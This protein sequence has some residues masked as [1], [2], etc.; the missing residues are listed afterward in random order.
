MPRFSSRIPDRFEPNEMARLLEERGAAGAQILDL[1]ESNPT[2][3][4]L[5][6]AP[7]DDWAGLMRGA[8][9]PYEP[10]PLG[11]WVT[12][13]AIS[14]YY[15]ESE[16]PV[17]AEHIVLTA[18]TSEAYAHLFRIFAEPGD[19]FLIPAPSYPLFEP[20][21]AL[22]SVRLVRYPLE[23][24]KNR[25]RADLS[26]LDNAIGE[27]TR[28]IIVVHPNNP[29][30]SLLSHAEAHGINALCAARDLI[31]ISDEVFGDFA[32]AYED[33]YGSFALN[34]SALTFVLAGLSKSCGVPQAKLAWIVTA[35]PEAA[36][37]QALQRLEWVGDTFLSV[38]STIQAAAPALL[39]NRSV[40]QESVIERIQI[41]LEQLDAL[42]S[43][44]PEIE[45]LIVDG[46]WSVVLRVSSERSEDEWVRDL[47]RQDVAVFPG[48]FFDFP[49]ETNLVISLLPPPR[50]FATA[51]ERLCALALS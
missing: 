27:R 38:S 6:T 34:P 5:A 29:T 10:E 51:I 20:L 26:A 18:S 15:A 1:T 23:Y 4:D 28:G 46:G 32:F 12:R 33:R 49:D 3:V 50:V 14:N 42:V 24:K 2:R 35:G 21:A 40:F 44:H 11:S 45:R 31:L 48:H 17:P 7:P 16:V 41:N 37:R 36:V 30:G 39:A 22:E 43:R 47:L 25:W 8:T 19:E 9:A 13:E